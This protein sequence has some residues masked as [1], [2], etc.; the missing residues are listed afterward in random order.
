MT[1]P[2]RPDDELVSA[3]LDGMATL[4]ERARVDADPVLRAR[5]EEL[6]GVRAALAEP[7]AP[8]PA[9]RERA[10][11]AALAAAPVRALPGRRESV[12]SRRFLAVAAGVLFL[13]LAAGFLADRLGSDETDRATGAGDLGRA[14][15]GE[16]LDGANDSA[17]APE[18][19]EDEAL[20]AGTGPPIELGVVIDDDA[21]RSALEREAGL[22]ATTGPSDAPAAS[23]TTVAGDTEREAVPGDSTECQ[24]DL[25]AADPALTGLLVTARATYAGTPAV[26]FVF[27]TAEGSQRVVV[28]DAGACTALSRFTW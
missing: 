17:A 15:A 27:A 12:V 3:V 21:L 14:E 11:R 16:V 25:E 2:F 9:D 20:A 4:D 1:D 10:V 13:L 24:A 26:V 6:A 28:V 23:T 18:A 8:A 19:A 5:L 22:G 7:H